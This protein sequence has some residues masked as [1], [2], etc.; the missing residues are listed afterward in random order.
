M[1][2]PPMSEET[3]TKNKITI[4]NAAIEMLSESGIESI[5]ARTLS[6][7]T[8][9]N[10]ASIYR[11]FQDIDEV[12]LFSCVHLLQNY[13]V[14]MTAARRT[15]E[16]SADDISDD[17]IYMLSWELFCKHAFAHPNEYNTLFFSRH[18]PDL[19]KTITEYYKLFPHDRG[20]EDD[21]ILEGMYRTSDV[22]ERNLLLLIPVLEGRMSERQII[23][24]ND[25]TVSF[26][27][28]L[29]LQLIN[30]DHNVTPEIQTDRM[31]YACR[32]T[33]KI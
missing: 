14:E 30:N 25:M 6:N 13:T 22:R 18:S 4:I 31:L 20:S 3:I 11:Y 19:D 7:R 1:G 15:Y 33:L 5:S 26:F 21:I 8:G 23:L 12:V 29:L 24:I 32:F 10:S 27:Y 28:T 2:R 9:M 16:R 17:H